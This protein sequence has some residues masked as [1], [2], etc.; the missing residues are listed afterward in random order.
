M[1]ILT[2]WINQLINAKH[3]GKIS[4]STYCFLFRCPKIEGRSK[5]KN[6]SHIEGFSLFF[7][8]LLMSLKMRFLTL[9][10]RI[11]IT[12]SIHMQT[13]KKRK[14]FISQKINRVITISSLFTAQNGQVEFNMSWNKMKLEGDREQP[15]FLKDDLYHFPLQ[16]LW[17]VSLIFTNSYIK[18][19][20]GT[21][22]CCLADRDYSSAYCLIEGF[23]V[24][25][26]NSTNITTGL[27]VLQLS[28]EL[29]IYLFIHRLDQ[30]PSRINSE[31][32][33]RVCS[34]CTVVLPLI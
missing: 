25:L 6:A 14:G 20:N 8:Q 21:S 18:L 3:Q 26:N 27:T 10:N 15:L 23:Q 5:F 19:F 24:G 28:V 30:K 4:T 12:K 11:I 29:F 32:K 1:R 33:A 13:L 31:D 16:N 17:I 2:Y 34:I 9:Q 22:S 7:Q